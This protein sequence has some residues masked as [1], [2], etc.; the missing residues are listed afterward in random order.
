MSERLTT[1]DR[2]KTRRRGKQITR[3]SSFPTRFN[4]GNSPFLRNPYRFG[5]CKAR[6]KT[7]LC[8]IAMARREAVNCFDI[9]EL[10]VTTRTRVVDRWRMRVL[11]RAALL[12]ARCAYGQPV[13]KG[14]QSR[15]TFAWLYG[16]LP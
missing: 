1:W 2:R 11:F 4:E 8:L 15:Q 5:G 13:V 9:D 3:Q 7:R 16:H 14:K 6:S 10:F 12:S